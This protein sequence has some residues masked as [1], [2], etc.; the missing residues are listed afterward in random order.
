MNHKTGDGS[1]D[2]E[3]QVKALRYQPQLLKAY[4]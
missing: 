4:C 2:V 3:I 1:Q